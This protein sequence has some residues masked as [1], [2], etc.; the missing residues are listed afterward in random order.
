ME[1]SAHTMEEMQAVH[2]TF[3]AGSINTSYFVIVE[4]GEKNIRAH[5]KL[6]AGNKTLSCAQNTTVT[7]ALKAMRNHLLRT[8]WCTGTNSYEIITRMR[9]TLVVTDKSL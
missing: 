4:V 3:M 9:S 7:L 6:C 1:N 5:C 2:V 8:T